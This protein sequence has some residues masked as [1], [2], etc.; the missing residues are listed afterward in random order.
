MRMAGVMTGAWLGHPTTCGG[1][2]DEVADH[3]AEPGDDTG[4][5]WSILPGCAGRAMSP[6]WQASPAHHGEYFVLCFGKTIA[7]DQ[8][9]FVKADAS[10]LIC[11][12]ARSL[13]S[14]SVFFSSSSV[15]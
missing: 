2:R 13:S 5:G 12:F 10:L 6:I 8:A 7:K 15:S 4:E 3:R 9:A 14:L 11:L 1:Q